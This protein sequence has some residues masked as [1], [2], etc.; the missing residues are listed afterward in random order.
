MFDVTLMLQ[1]IYTYTLTIQKLTFIKQNL[2]TNHGVWT[3]GVGRSG[4]G[5]SG[6]NPECL[7]VRPYVQILT[8]IQGLEA[9]WDK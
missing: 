9:W 8:L 3:F 2:F 5:R 6:L 1:K 4:F 7:S